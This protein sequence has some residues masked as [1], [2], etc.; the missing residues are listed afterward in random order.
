MQALTLDGVRLAYGD[1]LVLDNVS[2][3]VPAKAVTVLAGRS[4]SGKSSLLAVAAGLQVPDAGRVQVLGR[5]M[6]FANPSEAAQLRRRHIGLVFQHLHLLGDLSLAENIAL[7]LRL[8][9]APAPV[10]Q[11]R[12][13]QLLRAFGLSEL[14]QRRP[15]QV[16]GG[17]AQR[18]AI[19]RAL[20]RQPGLLLV[21]EPTSNL[22]EANAQAVL[23]ALKEAARLGAGVL[24][25]SHDPL[26]WKAGPLQHMVAGRIEGPQ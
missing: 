23:Q 24:V 16:S 14:A 15:N 5:P 18:A 13:E 19:A 3:Q 21:D 4:G 9:G 20:A 6:P 26:V 1:R 17:E 12:V 22:D 2:L 11:Q 8:D 25:A 10:R 7:P